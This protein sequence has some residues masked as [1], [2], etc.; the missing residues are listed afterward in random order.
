MTIT[1]GITLLTSFVLRI[2]ALNQSL[3]HDEAIGA[4]VAR[5]N[6]YI[7]IFTNYIRLDNHPPLYYLT[8]KAWA[9]LFGFSEVSLRMLSILF[10]IGTLFFLYLIAKKIF[11]DSK[12]NTSVPVILLALSPLHIY[13]SQEVRMYAMAAL[14]ATLSF[15]S[16]LLTL[17]GNKK[18]WIL[19]SV[20]LVLMLFSDYMPVFLLPVYWIYAAIKIRD[21][22]WWMSFLLSQMPLVIAGLIWSPYLLAQ[23]KNMTAQVNNFP[24]WKTVVGGASVKM[25][26]LLPVKLI[27]GRISLENKTLYYSLITIC[28]LPYLYLFYKAFRVFKK[29]LL[30][31]LAFFVPIA[32]AI[33]VSF[34]VPVFNYFRFIFIIPIFCL[35]LSVGITEIRSRKGK[36]VAVLLIGIISLTAWLFFVLTPSLHREDWRGAVSAVESRIKK[37]EIV[38]FDFPGLPPGYDW[39]AKD[40]SSVRLAVPEF[41]VS[42]DPIAKQTRL[43]IAGKTGIYYFEYLRDLTDAKKIAEQMIE[44]AGFIKK[45]VLDGYSGGVGQVTYFTLH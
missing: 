17:E 11:K 36:I 29:Y 3:W 27:L 4:L 21:K 26:L 6:T 37:D 34:I 28:S 45:E 9:E 22:K 5:N 18:G 13:F 35:L 1:L 44:K 24:A 39:Y 42:E 43:A 16:F 15:Y 7:G 10:G 40:T 20:S 12:I 25:L 32:L 8:L 31:W 14:F 2:F 41:G 38:L 30:V 23:V 33:L 19:F